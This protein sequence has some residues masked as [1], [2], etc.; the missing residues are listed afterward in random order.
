MSV[1]R[2]ALTPHRLLIGV[3]GLYVLTQ[4]VVVTPRMFLG[5]DEA[6]YLSQFAPGVPALTMSAPRAPGTPLLTAPVAVFT[7][8]VAIIR[9]YLTL[10]SGL[11]VYLAY[12]P[13]LGLRGGRAVP[14]AALLFCGLWVSIFYGN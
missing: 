2:L 9:V 10:L 13:W 14:L 6:L 4:L 11:G 5:W 12:R 7:A 8:S 3:A 1:M